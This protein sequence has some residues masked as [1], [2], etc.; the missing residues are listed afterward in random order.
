MQNL[1]LLEFL[2]EAFQCHVHHFQCL[3][4]SVELAAMKFVFQF[5]VVGIEDVNVTGMC[6][7]DKHYKTHI[8]F[9]TITHPSHTNISAIPTTMNWKT[10]SITAISTG[11]AKH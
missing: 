11:T 9:D 6:D 1:H 8:L 3:V 4:V 2:A 7:C 10:N 5:M